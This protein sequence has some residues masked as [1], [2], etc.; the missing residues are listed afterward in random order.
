MVTRCKGRNAA[1]GPCG[2]QATQDG[3]CAWHDPKRQAE[4]TE[5]RRRGG[6]AKSNRARASKELRAGSLSP[7]ELQGVI[8]V[9]ITQV[10]A[11]KKSP[12]IGQAIAAL[13]RASVAIREAAEVQDRLAALESVNGIRRVS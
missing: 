5:A 1:G 7:A 4:M 12:G 6:M 8:G 9:T 11:G 13:A 3:W 2:A 10:L